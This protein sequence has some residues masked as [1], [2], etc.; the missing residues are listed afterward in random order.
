MTIL[1][2]L[3]SK[4][5]AVKL[6]V[7][8]FRE[9]SLHDHKVRISYLLFR[10]V[11]RKGRADNKWRNYFKVSGKLY[12]QEQK[13][14]QDIKEG[15][16]EYSCVNRGCGRGIVICGGGDRLYG[17]GLAIIKTI[18]AQGCDLPVEW[19][20][21]DAGEMTEE[22]IKLLET[23]NVE[24]SNLDS[25]PELKAVKKRGYQS[26]AMAIACSK[27]Q[28][29][30]F[31]DCDNIPIRNP[32]YLFELKEYKETGALFWK[33]LWR[34]QQGSVF[35]GPDQ[36]KH[37]HLLFGIQE[38]EVGEFEIESGQILIDKSRHWRGVHLFLYMNL[39]WSIYYKLL[40]GDKDT[41]AI[42]IK[43]CGSTPSV[44][45]APPAAIGILDSDNIFSG[46][47]MIQH[48]TL[49]DHCFVHM[50]MLDLYVKEQQWNAFVNLT[51]G[52]HYHA[53]SQ[54]IRFSGDTFVVHLLTPELNSW[55]ER[56]SNTWKEILHEHTDAMESFAKLS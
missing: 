49:G 5:Q 25:Y 45:D 10:Y 11:S 6:A 27:F 8:Q 3:Q 42:A 37:M 14:I 2:E 16:F 39:H 22:A 4:V 9:M 56:S 15:I 41:Y 30:L 17:T 1:Q 19:F 34:Y 24:C 50:T 53:Q 47:G 38:P 40:Y 18:R 21:A 44:V 52:V 32:S 55:Q 51:D 29:V 13:N 35:T 31:L 7:Q 48:D 46:Y 28:E 12:L 43:S 26:K 23:F 20:Y 36:R 33:D 54:S